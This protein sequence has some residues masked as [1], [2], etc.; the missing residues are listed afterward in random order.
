MSITYC[1]T[2]PSRDVSWDSALLLIALLAHTEDHLRCLSPALCCLPISDSVCQGATWKSLCQNTLKIETLIPTE[3]LSRLAAKKTLLLLSLGKD[4]LRLRFPCIWRED[5]ALARLGKTQKQCTDPLS[6]QSSPQG[7]GRK[8]MLGP[9]CIDANTHSEA[10]I[11]FRCIPCNG[12][13]TC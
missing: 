4:D 8:T 7:W 1:I 9:V 3:L 11:W 12:R 2:F 10:F 13:I 6:Y 5:K